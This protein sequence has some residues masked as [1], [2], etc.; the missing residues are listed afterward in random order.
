MLRH[1]YPCQ[2]VHF[3]GGRRIPRNFSLN[4]IKHCRSSSAV[5]ASS[6]E[7]TAESVFELL[8]E[9]AGGGVPLRLSSSKNG[10]GIY[11]DVEIKKGEVLAEIPLGM[12]MSLDYEGGGLLLPRGDWPRVRKA[13][14]KD[15]ALP[16]DV[17]LALG[18]LDSMSGMGSEALQMYTNYVLPHPKSMS[19]PCCLPEHMLV[20]LQDEDMMEKAMEQKKRL[21]SL[22]PG[23]GVEMEE[24]GPT[25]MEYAFG[26]V[27]SR[28]F[29][30]GDESYGFVPIL[31]AANHAM[32]PN[33]DFSF[34]PS[35]NTVVVFA[36]DDVRQGEEVTISYTGKVGYTNSRMMAQ[37]G[38]V[39]ETGNPFDRYS[40][41]EMI[42][43]SCSLGLEHIQR[44]L[45]DGE[46]MV[47]ILSGKDAH[48]YSCMKSLP[49]EMEDEH[50]SPIQEQKAYVEDLRRVWL[51]RI[52][53]W[54][55]SLRDDESMLGHIYASD[56]SDPRLLAVLQYRIQSKRRDVAMD[57]LLQILSAYY[58]GSHSSR[59]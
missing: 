52:G 3:G 34:N 54:T 50:A 32:E 24:D 22:F 49:I 21:K 6:S 12:C 1:G 42:E 16:W 53:A 37:Y 41:D 43:R 10:R 55:S 11:T 28:A 59:R 13:I 17:L 23:L 44:A 31:D 46:Q 40:V 18:V 33:V 27:R 9:Q 47:D 45:G 30:L 51:N 38:F 4:T 57:G 8:L 39:F 56:K 7:L 25:W 58:A 15:D 19:L 2:H 5:N 14:E 26:C 29:K 36:I 35:G 48:S 20:E